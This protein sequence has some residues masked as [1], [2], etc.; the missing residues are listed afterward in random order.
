MLSIFFIENNEGP[1]DWQALF[2]AA[3]DFF[4]GTV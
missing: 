2:Q 1:G 4:P 3:G